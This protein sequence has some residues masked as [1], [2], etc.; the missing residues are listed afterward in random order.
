MVDRGE[1]CDILYLDY[2]NAFDT[3]P[4][5]RLLKSWRQGYYWKDSELDW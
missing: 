4:H 2:S 3:V 5:E 1:A